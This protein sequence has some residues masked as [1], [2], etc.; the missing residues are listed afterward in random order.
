MSYDGEPDVQFWVFDHIV[1]PRAQYRDRRVNLVS[2]DNV[3]VHYQHIADSIETIEAM[4][5]AVLAEG[6]EGLIL[7][8]PTAPYKFG[9]STTNEGYLLKLKRF[10]DAEFTIIG[11][12]E[13][14]HNANVA[15]IDELGRTKRSS[16]QENLIGRGDLGAL[17]L[18][19][20]NGSFN[21]GTGFDDA[22]RTLLWEQRFSLI[23]QKAKVKYFAVGGKDVPRFPVFLGLR[24]EGDM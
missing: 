3:V 24:H 19:H 9:R 13:R 18:E 10:A 7:R 6:H 16:H 21:V 17:V 1:D 12:E 2:A 22:T 8:S 23:G 20:E 14:M 15:T 4:E 11:F 5:A